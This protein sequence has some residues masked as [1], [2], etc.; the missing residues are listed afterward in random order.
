MWCTRIFDILLNFQWFICVKEWS[1]G[2]II[3]AFVER[4]KVSVALFPGL[5]F[6]RFITSSSGSRTSIWLCLIATW[7]ISE[8]RVL[9]Q[10]SRNMFLLFN[11]CLWL[12]ND[13]RSVAGSDRSIQATQ[14]VRPP[15]PRMVL[16]NPTVTGLALFSDFANFGFCC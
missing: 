15:I 2:W 1:R 16:S 8:S 4:S 6:P 9:S 5:G 12:A 13:H 14:T 3:V 10:Q 7:C 11:N